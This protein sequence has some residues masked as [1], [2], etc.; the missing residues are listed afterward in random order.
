MKLLKKVSIYTFIILLVVSIYKDLSIHSPI[1]NQPDDEDEL[2]EM[3]HNNTN[4]VKVKVQKGETVLS[5][6][7]RINKAEKN[8]DIEQIL[9]DFKAS[10]PN[11]DPYRL[12]SDTFYFFPIYD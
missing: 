11:A 3:P 6:V 9:D 8:L 1:S 5:I 2:K 7:E 10:N 12:K 4:V